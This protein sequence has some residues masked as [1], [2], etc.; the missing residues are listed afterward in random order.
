[1]QR[2]DGSWLPLWFGNQHAG[3]D[4]NPTYGTSK[5]LAAYRDLDRMDVAIRPAKAS[6][7]F[8]PPKTRD[9]GWGGARATPS[10]IEETAL[11]VEV[12]LDPSPGGTS[13]S[14]EPA[15]A[16]NKG[17]CLARP[18]NRVGSTLHPYPDWLLFC[19]ALVF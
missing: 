6:A 2:P 8:S 19:Q 3:D 11:A 15:E 18:A 4:M 5:V 1:M 16:V 13:R 14:T 7:G 17:L 9:G 10:S 12:L